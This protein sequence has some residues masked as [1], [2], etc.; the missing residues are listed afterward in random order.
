MS[1]HNR[2]P[3]MKKQTV[4]L[5]F[6]RQ[7]FTSLWVTACLLV[8]AKAA[9]P[10]PP[11]KMTY[12]GYLVDANGAALAPSS[13]ANYPVVFRIYD[14]SQGGTLLWAEDQ[15]VT[16]DKGGFS[17]V[18]GEG[19]QHQSEPRDALS[20]VFSSTGASD[21]YIGISV[22]IGTTTSEIAPRLRLLPAPYAF[23][24]KSANGLVGTDGLPLLTTASGGALNAGGSV[25]AGG[26]I[27]AGDSL[28]ASNSVSSG[29]SITAAGALASAS[30]NVTGTATAGTFV[31]NG[32]IPVGGIILWSG[33][34]SAVPVGWAL[35]DGLV[36]EG[37]TTP[38]LRD[39]FVIGAGPAFPVGAMGGA[40]SQTLSI[41]QMPNH[42][43]TYSDDWF[44]QWSDYWWGTFSGGAFVGHSRTKTG[45]S[46]SPV[47]GGSPVSI[48]P[49][50][51]AL[52][53]IM[54]VQ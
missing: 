19:T 53:Y 36:H 49:P 47:G 24:A 3:F 17:V 37:L 43:H 13:P 42:S 28:T 51:Y 16:V 44:E 32:I 29:G 46:T 34:A 7:A 12:Q 50:Y 14:A 21:R 15:I 2:F 45:Q 6:A 38:N 20:A 22:T 52:A 41:A 8:S 33:S 40:T 30:L 11:D 4:S 18:L 31:G 5:A 23:L 54:R 9:G 10:T 48:M 1:I 25:F 39:R 35:C 26:S 27:N